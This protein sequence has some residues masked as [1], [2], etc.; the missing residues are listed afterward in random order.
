MN[1]VSFAGWIWDEPQ[2]LRGTESTAGAGRGFLT[3]TPIL[4]GDA[5]WLFGSPRD[6]RGRGTVT[7]IEVHL[8]KNAITLERRLSE[9]TLPPGEAGS[10]DENGAILGDI[11]SEGGAVRITYVGF[12]DAPGQKFVART[13]VAVLD[14][15]SGVMMRSLEP[16]RV[17]PTESAPIF[18]AIHCIRA[19]AGGWEALYAA[20]HGWEEIGGARFPSY[21]TFVAHGSSQ[22]T[23]LGSPNP[24]LPRPDGVYRLGRPRWFLPDSDRARIVATGGRRTGDYRPYVFELGEDGKYVESPERFPFCP[25][26]F[27]W[28]SRQL[29]YPTAVHLDGETAVMFMNGDQMGRDGCFAAL[30]RR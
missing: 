24:L 28:C 5:I 18:E 29:S 7:C 21:D 10:F 2:L 9:L 17:H 26:D 22:E 1:R 27:P 6:D 11:L 12:A 19:T 13:G 4:K 16:V 20:G 15:I 23:L 14:P 30:G 3:P 25:G 8:Q